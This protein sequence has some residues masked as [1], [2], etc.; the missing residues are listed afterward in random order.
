MPFVLK[1]YN[2]TKEQK[3]QHF[4]ANEAN[5]APSMAQKLISK[6]RVFDEDGKVIQNSQKIKG[7]F[8][9]V[10]IF[11]GI[12]KGLKPIFNTKDF[13][14]FDKPTGVMVHPTSRTT[15]YTLLD[16]IRYHF[17]DGANLAHRIDME[18][19][20]LVMVTKNKYADMELKVMFENRDYKKEY[21]AIVDGKI[22]KDIT[23]DMPIKKDTSSLIGV[24][25]TTAKDGKESLTI[26][27]PIKYDRTKNQTY[28]KAI[29]HTGR[30]HQLRVHLD[31][32][33]HKIVGDPI[34]GV[35]EKI[36]DRYLLKK[37]NLDD[38]IKYT[39]AKR[40][41]LHSNRLCFNYNNID[42]DIYSKLRLI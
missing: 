22:D 7:R 39:G 3:I 31:S 2:I 38:R 21:L 12:T 37:L 32:V 8:I 16:E 4:L 25:M 9:Q 14:F 26:I 20:G 40:L 33:G 29:P 35:D 30:Q 6:A 10:A 11:E 19:S 13:A 15:S 42:Y 27:K 5:I 18:T 23:I 41:L 36:A 28:I 24:K 34:Y 17:G 1:K